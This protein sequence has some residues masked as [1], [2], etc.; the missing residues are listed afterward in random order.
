M[1]V[2]QLVRMNRARGA[3]VGSSCL[4]GGKKD[5]EADRLDPGMCR[6]TKNLIPPSLRQPLKPSAGTVSQM[7]RIG[8]RGPSAAIHFLSSVGSCPIV[9]EGRWTTQK[10]RSKR[11]PD[12]TA[13]AVMKRSLSETR[14]PSEC[15][16]ENVL[17]QEPWV[18]SRWRNM[19]GPQQGRS[20]GNPNLHRQ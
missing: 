2:G 1:V 8:L 9:S 18:M 14:R 12:T 10:T 19:A 7:F 6:S 13:P 4:R 11:K 20:S 15:L 17:R 5:V 3:L 16:G